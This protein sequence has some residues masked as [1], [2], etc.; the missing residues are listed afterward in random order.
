MCFE[1]EYIMALQGHPRS[2][3]LAPIAR[4]RLPVVINSNLSPILP[5]F[6]DIAGYL[7]RRATPPLFHLN[8]GVF[9]L[10]YIAD[11]LPSRSEDP[12]LINGVITFELTQHIRPRYINV[13]NRR[14]DRRTDDSR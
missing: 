6:R 10:D 13:P 12:K 14:T 3:I 2:L 7:L 5:R 8:F 11:V 9:P 1:T 4:I